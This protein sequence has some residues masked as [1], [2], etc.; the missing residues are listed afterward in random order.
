M[1]MKGSDLTSLA[2]DWCISSSLRYDLSQNRI[3]YKVARC[4]QDLD[5][6]WLCE[7]TLYSCVHPFNTHLPDAI[8]Y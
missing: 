5:S 3:V 6:D 2:N 8:S 7:G 1:E 4:R